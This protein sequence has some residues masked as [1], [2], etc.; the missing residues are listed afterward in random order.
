MSGTVCRWKTTGKDW[1]DL[2]QYE[3][4][5][6]AYHGNYCGGVLPAM[7]DLESAVEYMENHA[8]AV[9]RSDRPSL[10]RVFSD[11]SEKKD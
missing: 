10:K 7:P 4:G 9:L 6:Y 11:F 8:V 5:T 2:V 3:D 1:L